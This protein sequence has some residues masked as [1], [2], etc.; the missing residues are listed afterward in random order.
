MFGWNES[1]KSIPLKYIPSEHIS[2]KSN[3]CLS[4][5]LSAVYQ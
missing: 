1:K 3:S 4:V 5:V 2:N